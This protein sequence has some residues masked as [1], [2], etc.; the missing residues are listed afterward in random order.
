MGFAAVSQAAGSCGRRSAVSS[1]VHIPMGDGKPWADTLTLAAALGNKH[2]PLMALVDKYLSSFTKF[3]KV[4]FQ[5]TPPGQSAT[6]QRER[7][8]V[9]NEDQCYLLLT[10]A[11]N[12]EKVVDLKTKLVHE[13]AKAREANRRMGSAL[14][15][16]RQELSLFDQASK[17]RSTVFGRGMAQRR[18]EKRV[19]DA[20]WQD[21][22][23]KI[24]RKL[25]GPDE[26]PQ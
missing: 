24:Q 3:G 4:L 16:Q 14:S 9:L 12:N 22:E 23:G 6:G 17:Q 13:F 5:K 25:F 15:A 21:L 8:A 10:M 7:Y 1:I 2:R 18:A 11:R 26:S 20:R 19:I